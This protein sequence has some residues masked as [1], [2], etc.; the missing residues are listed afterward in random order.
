PAAASIVEAP[1]SGADHAR[2]TLILDL[3]NV[4][5]REMDEQ[6]ELILPADESGGTGAPAVGAMSEWTLTGLTLVDDPARRL[7]AEPSGRLIELA[8]QRAG[9][10]PAEREVVAAPL[11]S[12]VNRITDLLREAVS[13]IHERVAMAAACL[14]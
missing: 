2:V 1:G 3:I 13:K 14:V 12:L 4:S 10:R 8:E 5:V 11:A 6:G 7:L 9:G